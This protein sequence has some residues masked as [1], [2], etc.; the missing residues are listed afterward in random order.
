MQKAKTAGTS[1]DSR[2]TAL[3]AFKDKYASQYTTKFKAEPKTR[4]DYIPQST[5]IGG[6]SYPV[7]YNTQYGG[8]GYMGAGS[9]WVSYDPLGDAVMANTLMGRNNYVYGST[10]SAVPVRHVRQAP[11]TVVHQNRSGG[12]FFTTLIIMVF[13]VFLIAGVAVAIMRASKPE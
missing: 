8:Y 1:Y 3:S 9:A 13:V 2:T 6:R 11:V 10:M 4:P 12:G 7:A 5:S